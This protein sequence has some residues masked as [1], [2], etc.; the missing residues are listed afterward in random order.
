MQ[1][2]DKIAIMDLLLEQISLRTEDLKSVPKMI[3]SLNKVVGLN[4]FKKAEIGTPVFDT[5]DRYMIMLES[6]NGKISVEVT[7]YKET[8]SPSVDFI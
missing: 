1:N 6:L 8:L 7:Y 5:G 4:G 2:K 3:G